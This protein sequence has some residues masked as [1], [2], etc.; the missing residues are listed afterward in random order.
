MARPKATQVS[1]L[2]GRKL[3]VK[4]LEVREVFARAGRPDVTVCGPL[5]EADGLAVHAAAF[6]KLD[7]AKP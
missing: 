2:R 1:L 4:P 6:A 5:M 3:P 7:A